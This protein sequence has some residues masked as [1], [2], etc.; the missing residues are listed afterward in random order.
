MLAIILSFLLVPTVSYTQD[1][2]PYVGP[3]QRSPSMSTRF[4]IKYDEALEAI[5][6]VAV[7]LEA[8]LSDLGA[9]NS[10]N[11]MVSPLSMAVA[12]GEL[13]LG[14]RGKL[15]Q[16]LY[17]LL[18]IDSVNVNRSESVRHASNGNQIP[19]S[20][21][22]EQLGDLMQ[23]LQK[24]GIVGKSYSLKTASVLFKQYNLQLNEEYRK[25]VKKYYGTEIKDVDFATSPVVTE[26]IVNQWA[27]DNTN[28]LIK[29]ILPGPVPPQ[30]VAILA[31]AVYFRGDWEI[32][33]SSEIN[34]IG[35]FRTS[36]NT[37]V[38][39]TYM[40]GEFE[41]YKYVDN[42]AM[43]CKMV[44]IPYQDNELSMYII[45]PNN[46][47]YDIN[48]FASDLRTK[49]LL[50][51]IQQARQRKV[52]LMLPKMSLSNTIN[53]LGP[54]KRY[55]NY[56]NILDTKANAYNVSGDQYDRLD[57]KINVFKN[58]TRSGLSDRY[59]TG[60]LDLSGISTDPRFYLSDIYQQ[61][62]LSVNEQ[63][64]EAAAVAA[65]A[66]DYI[67]DYVSF[68]VDRPF[69]FFIRHEETEA[70]LFWG[71]IADPTEEARN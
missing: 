53:V 14:A 44:V 11:F 48:K 64:T 10:K 4:G 60:D 50:D 56:K 39:V 38:N 13:M 52:F 9:K 19:F 59:T 7:R 37:S 65:S 15:Q 24:R 18:V 55:H 58:L 8:L 23:N 31:N 71:T 32:P 27:V 62:T 67:L 57:D 49:D 43:D 45:L 61:M 68:R 5:F 16:Q 66:I 42:K 70:T 46:K 1:F 17:D 26:R 40:M 35:A 36:N 20:A 6:S 30:T 51:L 28:G 12:V 63:G 33:F 41:N 25:N 34:R 21:L 3:N 2:Q 54:L 22:H 69:L 29:T 47:E